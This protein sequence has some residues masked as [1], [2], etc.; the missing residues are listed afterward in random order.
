MTLFQYHRYKNQ[1]K[2]SLHDSPKSVRT[3][4]INEIGETIRKEKYINM[5]QTHLIP[6]LKRKRKFKDTLF[7]QDGATPHTAT[8]TIKFLRNNFGDR[9]LSRS[10]N[11]FWSAQSPHLTPCDFWLWNDLKRNIYI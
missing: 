10:F 4:V 9:V 2:N 1:S 11:Y 8:E 3:R 6:A 5:I 7:M